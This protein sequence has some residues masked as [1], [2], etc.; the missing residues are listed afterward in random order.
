MYPE[1]AI[2]PLTGGNWHLL[3]SVAFLVLFIAMVCIALQTPQGGR[4]WWALAIVAGVLTV[5]GQ[6]LTESW[7]RMAL[8]DVAALIT[9]GMVWD[10]GTNQARDAARVY[11]VLLF[12]SI[13]LMAGGV[14]LAVVPLNP[15]LPLAR[16]TAVLLIGGFGL[17]LALIP[18][19]IWLP[20]V[21]EHA[22]PLTTAVIVGLI[23]I[24][25]FGELFQ[26]RTAA[27]W[28]FTGF[29]AIWLAVALLSMVGGA[30]LAL[31]ERDIKRILAFSTIAGMG[32]LMIGVI[33]GTEAGLEGAFIGSLSHALSF[34]LLFSA[35]GVA[36]TRTGH[37]L[38]LE[39]RGMAS[40]FPVSGMAF[41]V[42]A[43]GVIGIPPL[44]GFVGDWQLYLAGAEY[45]GAALVLAM[46]VVG[47]L[48]TLYYLR[49]VHHVWMGTPGMAK[50]AG[51]PLMTK[52]VMATLVAMA[53]LL[54]IFPGLVSGLVT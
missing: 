45:G 10:R 13:L 54:G 52:A 20:G 36:E 17:K 15:A 41:L 1:P 23:D 37:S 29:S 25:V 11:L 7:I 26:I 12:F 38:T 50:P 47:G 40:A 3:F 53:I 48:T 44:L 22:T 33:A 34:T 30:L 43:L 35:V 39:D 8:L 49:V 28:V 6:L 18:F 16:L 5:A 24:S 2:L 21:A 27:P 51:E 9:V 46:A 32:Y 42:G 4:R 31:G 14:A 19:F